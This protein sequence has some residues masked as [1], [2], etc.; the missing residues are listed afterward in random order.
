[1][2][3]VRLP[4]HRAD[5]SHRPRRRV[6]RGPIGEDVIA[7]LP[8][9]GMR[10]LAVEDQPDV[11][12]NIHRVLEEQGASV[13]T[14][15]SAA[16]AL[17]LLDRRGH[18]AFDLLLSDIGMPGMDGYGL[19]RTLR[20]TMG[21]SGRELPAVAVTALARED[22]RRR[23]FAAGFQA[24]VAKPYSLAQLVGAIRDARLRH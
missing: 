13:I 24:H 17:E 11:L 19:V 4:A 16:E 6:Q 8:L 20:E 7:Q 9:Q 2:F 15:S 14:A 1:V 10:L 12:A 23:A 3:R 22:D 5:A 18:T 21:V